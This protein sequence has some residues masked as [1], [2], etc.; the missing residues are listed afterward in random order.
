MKMLVN[1]YTR[2]NQEELGAEN[3]TNRPKRIVNCND[4]EIT[5]LNMST[6]E[7]RKNMFYDSK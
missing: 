6:V 2:F 4:R 7:V 3:R 5:S 1:V